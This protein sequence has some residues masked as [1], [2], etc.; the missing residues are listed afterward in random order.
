MGFIRGKFYNRCTRIHEILG[1]VMERKLYGQ[2]CKTLNQETQDEMMALLQNAPDDTTVMQQYID[3]NPAF[4]EHLKQYELYFNS[5]M[6]GALGPTAQYWAIYIFMVNRIHRELMRALRTND[7]NSYISILPAVI[8]ICFG[9]NRHRPNYARWGVLFL[10]KLSTASPQTRSV[11]EKGTFSIRRTKKN[12]SRSAIDLTL[13]QTVNR[14]AASPMRGIIGFQNS[15]NAVR[16]WCITSTERGMAV[17]ELRQLTG[18]RIENIPATQLRPNRIRKDN[19]HINA[20][21]ETLTEAC[22]PFSAPASTTDN[23]L[24]LATGKA[25]ATATKDYLL[26]TLEQG[27]YRRKKFQEECADDENRVMKSIQRRKVENF[28]SE[29][30]KKKRKSTTKAKPVTEG[31]RDTFVPFMVVVSESTNFDLKSVLEFPI[32]DY[33][34]SIAHGDGS[35]MKTVKANLLK[36]LESMQNGFAQND[37]PRI[38]VT[39]IDGGLLLHSFLSVTSSIASYANLARNMLSHVCSNVGGEIHVL[40]DT[41]IQSSIK[42]TTRGRGPTLC[43]YWPRASTKA[44]WA[45][46]AEERLIQRSAGNISAQR[47]GEGPLWT[48]YWK[49]TSSSI[50][51]RQ[52]R[53]LHL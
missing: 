1:I 33:P 21:M 13:E 19:E 18:L 46:V 49:E 30:S 41:Y 2:F 20:L 53:H 40:F 14:D 38:D 26:Q 9:L 48:D 25:T 7:V 52:M 35:I 28:A 8:D 5:V 50:I 47:M 12:Y 3:T 17:T 10:Q 16:R 51:W 31:V 6:G 44:K 4:D 45:A 32:T 36:K 29:N 11:L 37:L 24:N 39:V 27:K 23:L 42:T 22:D 43:N 34:L 15:E